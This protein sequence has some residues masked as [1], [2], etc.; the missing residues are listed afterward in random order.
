VKPEI[1]YAE[2]SD[3]VLLAYQVIGEG[4]IDIVFVLGGN[5]HVDMYWD[6][7]TQHSLPTLL[8]RFARIILFD[9]RG[10]G[11]SERVVE[12]PL[13]EHQVDDIL[14]VMSAA[15]CETGA[16]LGFAVGGSLAALCAASHPERVQALITIG[17]PAKMLQSA[18][19]EWGIDPVV[20]E[21]AI[22]SFASGDYS[23]LLPYSILDD[24]DR[25]DWA[26][27][28]L[29]LGIGPRRLARMSS[30]VGTQVDI[31]DVLPAVRV[32]TLVLHPTQGGLI[33]VEQGRYLA[34]TIP[35]ARLVEI[36]EHG[37][38]ALSSIAT[39]EVA[40]EVQEFLTGAPPVRSIDRVL[41][42]VLFTDIVG[43]TERAAEM[44]DA[45]WKR[46]LDRHD[47]S[48]AKAVDT[49]R[50]RVVKM[51]GD[52]L[53]A[54]FDGPARAIECAQQLATLAREM[55]IEIRAGLH[56]GEVELRGEPGD[57]GEGDIGG[58][59]VHIASRIQGLAGP[60]EI[61]V[62]RTVKDLVAG[63]E[64]EFDDRGDHEL[65]GVPDRWQVLAVRPS[66]ES[67][68]P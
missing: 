40:R 26:F 58:I 42:T 29:A 53:L 30:V 62:S 38:A 25:R 65:K 59:A 41:A 3:G 56:T 2:A 34:D 11:M 47:E 32:P 54:T 22:E 39:E 55:G 24:P 16:L 9:R 36:S 20:W 61:L 52:G 51:T 33:S 21:R 50:G 35:D 12:F 1:H 63:S 43:S 64:I 14:T 27:R 15:G 13:L 19:W 45:G 7:A 6:P 17:T 66:E 60:G 31:R 18:D 57:S 46:L 8:S 48:A 49:F 37:G 67:P 23:P 68:T 10:W 5:W 28:A 44:G 4:P